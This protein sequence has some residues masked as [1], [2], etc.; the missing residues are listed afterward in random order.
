MAIDPSVR[1]PEGATMGNDLCIGPEVLLRAALTIADGVQVG[2]RAI[3]AD[4]ADGQTVVRSGVRIGAS[5]IIGAGIEIGQGAQIRA[6]AVVV[7]NVPPNAIVEGNPARIT[8][9]VRTP[10]MAG[11]AP[12]ARLVGT[13]DEAPSV[14]PLGIGGAALHRMR[15]VADIRG[16]LTVGE[17]DKELPF[18]PRR[19]F[20]VF[21]VPSQELRGEHAHRTC[22]QFLLC[23]HGSCNLLLDDGMSRCEVTLDR[24]D[25][26]VH[27]PP[28]IWG[29]QYRYSPDAVLL[30]FASEP[31]D[32]GDYIRTYDDFLKALQEGGE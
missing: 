20:L 16:A 29:T 30:V 10:D 4:D 26:G 9:Y 31:Y 22:H 25:L 15:R 2:P 27:M 21:D 7:S 11:I 6:G 3:F 17:V 24:P 13:G 32:P 28:M 1:L 23:V 8:G 18:R 14:Q 12:V 19:Y 5:A